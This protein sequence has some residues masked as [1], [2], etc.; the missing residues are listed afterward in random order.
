MLFLK[1][2]PGVDIFSVV[3]WYVILLPA[4]LFFGYATVF[5]LFLSCKAYS[6]DLYFCCPSHLAK[7]L[8]VPPFGSISIDLLILGFQ[9]EFRM[10]WKIIVPIMFGILVGPTICYMAHLLYLRCPSKAEDTKIEP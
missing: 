1:L 8:I 7:R 5:F 9:I 6:R 2:Y 4:I 10:P 3:P